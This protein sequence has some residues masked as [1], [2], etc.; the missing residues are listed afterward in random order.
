MATI[1]GKAVAWLVPHREADFA[2]TDGKN[3][4]LLV[5]QLAYL[6]PGVNMATEGWMRM[7]QA[8]ITV[9]LP[10]REDL[11][12]TQV[13]ALEQKA[14]SIQ[15]EAQREVNAIR[16]RISKLQALTFDA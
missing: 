7:G 8:E 1:K 3:H 5:S 10:S 9:E 6:A 13:D 2:G 14:R 4:D 12:R 16:D 15:A 11:V